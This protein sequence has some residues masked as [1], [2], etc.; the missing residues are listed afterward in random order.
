MVN[1]YNDVNLKLLFVGFSKPGMQNK[2][3]LLLA[4]D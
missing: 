3:D 1:I 2:V 4:N